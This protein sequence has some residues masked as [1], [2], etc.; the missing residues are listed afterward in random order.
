MMLQARLYE[1][2]RTNLDP[3]SEVYLAL[4]EMAI[5]PASPDR[6]ITSSLEM[7]I[8]GEVVD[9]YQGDGLLI[10]TPTGST[11]YTVAAGGP[12]I[13][14]GMDAIVVTPICPLSLSSRPIVLPPGSVV[15]VWPLA[16]P[17]L[18]TKLW[19]DGVMGTAIWPGQRVDVRSA[20]AM[21]QFII[22]RQDHSYYGTLR[23]KLN[24]A[25]SRINYGDNHRN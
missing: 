15:S 21:A 4:N 3:I 14:P 5:K 10:S 13:H 7:E 18:T 24:W 17:D 19:T 23:N 1:G 8:D 11:G 2:H 22:L 6:M 16:D 9:Q 20:E 12:I 25:G